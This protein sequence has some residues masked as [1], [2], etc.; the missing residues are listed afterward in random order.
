MNVGRI[1]CRIEES[2]VNVRV[3]FAYRD[4][5]PEMRQ[6]YL[7]MELGGSD[8]A[9]YLASRWPG[10]TLR[11]P[12]SAGPPPDDIGV[13]PGFRQQL[14]LHMLMAVQ[15]LNRLGKYFVS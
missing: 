14:W 4:R 11:R 3:N 8:L 13:S 7:L 12:A 9:S 5:N 2:V 6:R 10:S 1:A 15:Q